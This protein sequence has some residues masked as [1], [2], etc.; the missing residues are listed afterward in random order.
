MTVLD[1]DT[2]NDYFNLHTSKYDGSVPGVIMFYQKTCPYCKEFQPIYN[3]VA[4][5]KNSR[6]VLLEYDC[7]IDGMRT[8]NDFK[9]EG[10]PW[11]LLFNQGQSW[12]D[13]HH[14][15]QYHLPAGELTVK[16]FTDWIDSKLV[17]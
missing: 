11:V 2:F 6:Y 7:R 17:D 10:T 3:D 1:A 8:C 4:D 16:H 9:V 12:I 13:T 15:N 5:E 14:F